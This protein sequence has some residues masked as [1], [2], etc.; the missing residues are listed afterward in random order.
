MSGGFSKYEL[1]TLFLDSMASPG[2]QIPHRRTIPRS[3][4]D[5]FCDM[6]I[7]KVALP[8]FASI[9]RED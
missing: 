3:A 7:E 1:R 6:K 4:V 9:L 8:L 5:D 2:N